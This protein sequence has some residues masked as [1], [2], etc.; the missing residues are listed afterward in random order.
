MKRVS[1]TP[2][3][4]EPLHFDMQWEIIHP[5]L[6]GAVPRNDF[7][8][9]G[10]DGILDTLFQ[11]VRTKNRVAFEFG[12]ADGLYLSNTRR[13]WHRGWTVGL[14]ESDRT[15]FEKI[16]EHPRIRKFCAKVKRKT[17]DGLLLALIE[18]ENPDLLVMDVDGQEYWILAG[19]K[20]VRPRVLMVEVN[21]QDYPDPCAEEGEG[22]TSYQPIADLAKQM[23]YVPVAKNVIN[24]VFVRADVNICAGI[25]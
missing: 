4:P 17:V 20:I 18:E 14:I 25:G 7:S 2:F 15:L 13:L 21:A 10:E 16:P 12:A 22:Q 11:R 5:N 6:R 23:G 3:N 8:Q 19:L 24:V 1:F 9:F